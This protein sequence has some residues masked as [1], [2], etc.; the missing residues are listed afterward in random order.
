MILNNDESKNTH[1]HTRHLNQQQ[2]Y[3][4]LPFTDSS[5]DTV[6]GGRGKKAYI[7]AHEIKH[8]NLD[9]KWF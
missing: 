5:L 1:T 7:G 4:A 2:Q 8:K 9:R 6:E 3:I